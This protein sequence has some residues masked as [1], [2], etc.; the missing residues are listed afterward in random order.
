MLALKLGDE[1][2]NH[3]IVEVFAAKMRVAGRRFDL[4]DAVLD[5]E[6][7]DIECAAAKIEDEHV[8]LG[9]A[10]LVEA[11]GDGGGGRLVDDAQNVYAGDR[12]G[13]FCRLTLRVVEVGRHRDHRVFACAAEERFGR[14]LHLDENHRRNFLGEER[15]RLAF[16]L[17]R[18]FRSAALR[19][20]DLE[21][22][23][24]H[25]GLNDRIFEFAADK[26]LCI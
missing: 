19:V 12:A 8:A 24:L 4:E 20:D 21:R 5:G 2:R 26:A 11:I 6:D 13:V 1:M 17:D 18:D 10:L 14:L 9:A 16:E 25:V 7:R 15:F 22:P 23:M 3:A